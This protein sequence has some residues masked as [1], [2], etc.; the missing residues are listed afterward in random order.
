M[1]AIVNVS[2]NPT[3]TGEHKYE[4]R[5]NREVQAKFKH[6]REDGLSVC[7]IKAAKAIEQQKYKRLQKIVDSL[8]VS[9]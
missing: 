6:K 8:G 5:I 4:V 7:L 9:E 3:P 2:E 1:I